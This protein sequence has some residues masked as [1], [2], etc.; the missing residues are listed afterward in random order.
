MRHG[1]RLTALALAALALTAGRAAAGPEAFGSDGS[2]RILWKQVFSSPQDDWINQILPLRDG[3]FLAV[4][5]LGR[6]DNAKD[7]DWRALAVK[8]SGAGK[9]LWRREY[10]QGKGADA[11]WAAAEA[12]D[13]RI[14]ATGFTNRIGSGGLDAYA[15]VLGGD[16][17]LISEAAF[18]GPGYDR[19]TDIAPTIDGGFLLAGH[20]ESGHGG[21]RDVLLV[22]LGPDGAEQW[23][24]DYGGPDSEGALYLEPAGDG[25]FVLAGGT[26]ERGD[27]DVLVMKVDAEGRQLWR[28]VIGDHGADDTPHNLNILP[29]GRI[30][31]S[32]YTA[33][34]GSQ[35]HDLLSLTLSRE[36]ELLREEVM[37]GAGDDRAMVSGLDREGRT[38]ATGYTRSAGA[39]GWDIFLTRLGRDGGFEGPIATIGGPKDDNGTAVLPLADGDLL[40][41]AYSQNLGGGGQDA[42]VMRV[43]PPKAGAPDPRFRRRRL[44]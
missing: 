33:G 27:G 5:F 42:V 22:K 32:G 25:G 12:A 9:V 39:G 23:R 21:K 28:R 3:T 18:G 6:D 16:G 14:V 2:S 13:G 37:G 17:R 35:G 26:D 31:M 8:F 1:P 24:R 30:Q 44:S 11:F 4:G 10:G 40:V 34:Y 38:W 29:G 7:G 20:T 36:G 15:A 19:A 41:A 43:K